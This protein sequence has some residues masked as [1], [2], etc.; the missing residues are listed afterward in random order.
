MDTKQIAEEAVQGYIDEALHQGEI[1]TEDVELMQ[2]V[3]TDCV[4][5]LLESALTGVLQR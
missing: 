3:M 5:Y 1:N 4:L 2:P